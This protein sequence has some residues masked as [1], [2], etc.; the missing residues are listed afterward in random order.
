MKIH[1]IQHESFE[2]AGV[3]LTWAKNKQHT[4]S[5]SRIYKNDP[6][7]LNAENID[8][9]IVLGGPQSPN[10]TKEEFPYFDAGMEISLIRKC[11][12][13][14]IW[15]IGVCLGAQLIG[16]AL[17]AK[18]EQSPE[19][20][21]GIFPIQLT[22]DGLKDNMI[23]HFGESLLVGH[24]HN[25]M[26][27]L[28]PSSRVLATSIGCP[29]QIIKYH[30]RVYGFQCHMEFTPEAIEFLI[31]KEENFLNTQNTYKWIQK[32]VK[33]KNF[34]FTEMNEKLF[35]FLDKIEEEYLKNYSPK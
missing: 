6:V 5:F 29:R 10:S 12:E 16:E 30:K 26:P 28:I 22:N 14:N 18:F 19:K 1:F 13:A 21:I 9:L 34:D 23:S 11:I 35:V 27:G 4:I 2:T 15:V 31:N 17:G 32:P 20:E 8:L 25:D 24:W 33:M 3:Y 7:P